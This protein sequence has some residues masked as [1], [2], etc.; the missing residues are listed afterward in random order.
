M[1]HS[2]TNSFYKFLLATAS[3]CML[4]SVCCDAQCIE[5]GKV[6]QYQ[7]KTSKVVLGGVEILA[8]NAG[9]TISGVQGDFSLNFKKLKA[10]DRVK[11]MRV[12]KTGYI[13]F[14]KEAVDQ[15]HISRTGQPF[16]IVMCKEEKYRE[17]RNNYERIS[18]ESYAKKMKAE[19]NRLSAL[20]KQNKLTEENY[21]KRLEQLHYDYETQLEN[22]DTYIDRVSRYD[23]SELSEK[24]NDII[25]LMQQGKVDEALSAYDEMNLE[26]KLEREIN[27]IGSL[28][29][30]EDKLNKEAQ[31][32]RQKALQTYEAICRKN[33]ILYLAG[34]SEN[35]KKIKESMRKV[36]FADTTFTRAMVNY[37]LFL[38][39]DQ[40]YM[41]ALDMVLIALRNSKDDTEQYSIS[42]ITGEILTNLGEFDEAEEL[43]Q[44][45]YEFLCKIYKDEPELIAIYGGG[46]LEGM[47][48]LFFMQGKSKEAE[49][50][51]AQRSELRNLLNET[52]GIT[53]SMSDIMSD[54]NRVRNLISRHSF[55]AAIDLAYKTRDNL[56][57]LCKDSNKDF[58][59]KKYLSILYSHI[60]S[61]FYQKRNFTEAY[62][63]ID[64]SI[65]LLEDICKTHFNEY[66]K[67]LSEAYDLKGGILRATAKYYGAIDSYRKA[68]D[69]V[70]TLI[71][72]K[73]DNSNLL[74][75]F[76]AD[77]CSNLGN[78]YIDSKQYNE[79]IK[80]LKK[81]LIDYE[82]IRF[83]S[84]VTNANYINAMM[85]L[86]N[87][88][89][90]I[91]DNKN[92]IYYGKIALKSASEGYESAP[93]IFANLFTL[94]LYNYCR[95]VCLP[96]GDYSTGE[97]L[98]K[99]AISI[100]E[101][102]EVAHYDYLENSYYELAFLYQ[103][104][105]K[106]KEAE[107]IINYGV[108]H[109]PN[110]LYFLDGKGELLMKE[111]KRQEAMDIWN[112]IISIDPHWASNGSDFSKMVL[113][114]NK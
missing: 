90:N 39:K 20:R 45:S 2:F 44:Y 60:A 101:K 78:A 108:K 113:N 9:S 87:A 47:A 11:I 37:V 65:S 76:R 91:G 64:K 26:E 29:I 4:P 96:S 8:A 12:E 110:N 100:Y 112:K 6:M 35:I 63:N 23:L 17:I 22:L 68:I 53:Y 51:Y 114:N 54:I 111:G 57:K 31:D 10:G 40:E 77:V 105:G 55:D 33:D 5:K 109:F 79:C 67:A 83:K 84:I 69:M 41:E 32:N 99:K 93:S 59:R 86:N 97:T 95:T 52:L 43:Y 49:E 104:Q 61:A 18:S 7:G 85:G 50:V 34:G 66:A 3:I 24:E 107:D 25:S 16:T 30:A 102:K 21:K 94:S 38:E 42:L 28:S 72:I 1:K 98:I 13:L 70:D 74:I 36:A 62:T 71:N 81:A 106:N 88:Y 48:T 19:E 73:P 56:E 75:R 15:W 103:M 89:F 14:N 27:I 92:T 82:M 58:E 46:V 80:I